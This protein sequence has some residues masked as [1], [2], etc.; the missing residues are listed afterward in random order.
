MRAALPDVALGIHTHDD[1][2]CAVANTLVAVEAGA[3]QVQGTINGIGERTGNA[4]LVTI[5]ADLQ[6]KM[7]HEVL[8]PERL[9][10]LTETAHFVDE[11]L[12]RAPDA[13]QPYVGKHAFAHKAGLHVAGIRADAATFEHVD[14]ASVGNRRDVL[15]SRARGRGRPSTRRPRS[16]HRAGRRRRRARR[17]ARQGARAPRLPVRGRRRAPSS[18]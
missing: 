9:A 17:R 1:A 18:C 3:T 4:N 2:G 12:N 6:L 8:A 10:R 14:P 7:G 5:I 11:L 16:G 15:V 13:A